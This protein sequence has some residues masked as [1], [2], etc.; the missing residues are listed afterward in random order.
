MS[1][2]KI[3]RPKKNVAP[4]QAAPVQAQ[5]PPQITPLEGDT[6]SLVA[7]W[8]RLQGLIAKLNVDIK[9][10][11]DKMAEADQANKNLQTQGYQIMGAS[12][13]VSRLL[14]A[15][16]VDP[17]TYSTPEP[18]EQEKAEVVRIPRKTGPVAVEE[19]HLPEPKEDARDSR[20][21]AL[22]R[23]FPR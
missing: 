23:R 3:R 19:V 5:A 11:Q 10:N 2:K 20:L 17:N 13:Q 4:L 6:E 18:V 21:E 7:E 8:R 22:S 14:A 15:K 9:S 1:K 12:Q 16:G